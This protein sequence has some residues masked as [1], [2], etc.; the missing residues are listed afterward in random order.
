MYL[1]ITSDGKLTEL[2]VKRYIL[3]DKWNSEAQ[4]GNGNSEEIRAINAYLKSVEQQ[5]YEPQHQL[6]KD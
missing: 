4:K 5:E 1:R 3:P 2:A 6:L